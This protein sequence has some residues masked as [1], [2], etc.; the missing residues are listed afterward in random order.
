MCQVMEN[1]NILEYSGI[2]A[3]AMGRK[4]RGEVKVV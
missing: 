2:V 1:F 3:M 4:S